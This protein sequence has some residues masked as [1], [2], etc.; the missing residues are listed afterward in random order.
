LK[1]LFV[2][3][4]FAE[5]T[6]KHTVG[7]ARSLGIENVKIGVLYVGGCPIDMHY[8]HACE[9][10]AVYTYHLNEGEGWTQTPEFKISDTVKSDA[11]DWIV[12]QH[13]TGSGARY[14]DAECYKNLDPLVDYIKALAPS[15][16][17]A[18]NL[19][20][21]GEHT[22]Q[23]H[24]IISY[25]GNTALMREKL[26]EVT[27][28]V[29]VRNPK[30]DLLVPTG[31]AIENARTSKIGLLTRDCYHLSVDKGRYI[32]ALTF[33]STI[34]GLDAAKVDWA[35]DGVDEYAKKVALESVKNAQAKPLEITRSLL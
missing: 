29:V 26:E 5:D 7:V 32:A 1:V 17:I 27:R 6:S 21:M 18:F 30:I 20:W 35:P 10:S 24:E 9:D 31:T 19:T 12:I 2:G 14:T 11:W 4:S 34:T 22:F 28:E 15:A 25:G 13:G 8:K 33:I 3:N 16:K 23:H